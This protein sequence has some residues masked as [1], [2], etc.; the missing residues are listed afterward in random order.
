MLTVFYITYIPSFSTGGAI[1]KI[2]NL[3][4]AFH[5]KGVSI[6]WL[7]VTPDT[8][9]PEE[10]K[11]NPLVQ[12]IHSPGSQIDKA[13]IRF[14]SAKEQSNTILFFRYPLA[15]RS[16]YRFCLKFGK[17]IIFEHNT[18]EPE[19]LLLRLKSYRFRDYLYF[20]RKMEVSR[21]LKEI[22]I[23]LKERYWGPKVMELVRGGIGVTSEIAEF[24]KE[25]SAGYLTRVVGNGV[26]CELFPMHI[27]PAYNKQ[28]LDVL[29]ICSFPNQW[30]GADRLLKGLIQYKGSTAIHLHLVGRFP[31]VNQ[32]LAAQVPPKHQVTFYGFVDQA[33]I[34]AIKK[35]CHIGI[36]S[37]GMHRIPLFQGSV[38]KVREYLA[39]GMPVAIGYEDE[40]IAHS[41]LKKYCLS[42][43]PDES[44]VD[45]KEIVEFTALV[46]KDPDLSGTIRNIARE[47]LDFS[48]KTSQYMKCFNEL[49]E[50]KQNS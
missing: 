8:L 40:D 3:V 6:T 44:P 13:L 50:E 34:T 37:L 2:R 47:V 19:E 9:V 18:K 36:G 26:L 43:P 39:S 5:S 20:L 7:I 24:Q 4:N 35:S 22:T 46:M 15:S 48:V 17:R 38:L 33:S 32:K 11:S 21:L 1:S 12:I 41:E 16:L 27:Q 30:H 42:I 45:F 10:I 49:L 31:P 14:F 23:Y 25:R 29:L 28:R